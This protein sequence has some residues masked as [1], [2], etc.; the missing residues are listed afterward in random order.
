[1][2]I[3]AVLAI[4]K[5]R[6][7]NRACFEA[8]RWVSVRE[9]FHARV[10]LPADPVRECWAFRGAET[11]DGYPTFGAE[12]KHWSAHRV[13]YELASGP[14]PAGAWVLH[15]CHHPWCVNPRHL[16]LGDN[17]ENVRHRQEAGRSLSG[18]R[19]PRAKLT[20]AQVIELRQRYAAGGVSRYRLAKETGLT[21]FAIKAMLERRTWKHLP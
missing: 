4:G 11:G 18:E 5:G 12:G 19:N 9:G 2:T 1:V 6:Y 10:V 15:L 21:D 16:V 3:P 8:G 7:C 13:S 14:I 17:D 20:E